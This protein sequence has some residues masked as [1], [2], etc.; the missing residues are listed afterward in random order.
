MNTPVTE[1]LKHSSKEGAVSV[2]LF[3]YQLRRSDSNKQIT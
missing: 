1:M 3:Q 2:S